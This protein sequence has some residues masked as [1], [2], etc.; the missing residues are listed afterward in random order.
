MSYFA[1]KTSEEDVVIA[2]KAIES[3]NK[4]GRQIQVL[5]TYS[6]SM[7]DKHKLQLSASENFV[8]IGYKEQS[9]D[10][11][12]VNPINLTIPT[13]SDTTVSIP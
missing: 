4:D 5:N 11:V 8:N 13:V 3:W 6:H 1:F 2:Q 7:S 9:K 12:A 10:R